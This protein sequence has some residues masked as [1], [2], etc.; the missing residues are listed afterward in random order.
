[1]LLKWPKSGVI[2]PVIVQL[3]DRWGRPRWNSVQ[4][5]SRDGNGYTMLPGFE[6]KKEI[7][8]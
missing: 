2:S 3:I 7:S 1:M 6:V 4:T 5:N 8:A